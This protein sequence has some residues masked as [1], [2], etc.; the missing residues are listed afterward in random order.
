VEQ[1]TLLT[2]ITARIITPDGS[3]P[4]EGIEANQADF[5]K[6]AERILTPQHIRDLG[7]NT[8]DLPG[9]IDP[10]GQRIA[11]STAVENSTAKQ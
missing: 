3:N 9:Y 8:Q 10:N 4:A 7:L 6:P 5:S 2:F 1:R 11:H